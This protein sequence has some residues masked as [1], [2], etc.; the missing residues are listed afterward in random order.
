MQ[1][2]AKTAYT[3]T[4]A[5]DSVLQLAA[6]A[7]SESRFNDAAALYEQVLANYGISAKVL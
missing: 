1:A 4:S 3:E 6:T 5:A 7:Y 2:W